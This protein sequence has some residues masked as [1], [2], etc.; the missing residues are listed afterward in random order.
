MP[1]LLGPQGSE[2]IARHLD[3]EYSAGREFFT[4]DL[5]LPNQDFGG[6]EH[7]QY[8][9]AKLARES[10]R[11]G[12]VPIGV[13][14]ELPAN[15]LSAVAA[16]LLQDL[17]D[18]SIAAEVLQEV[19]SLL[20]VY[21]RALLQIAGLSSHDA[22]V[23]RLENLSMATANALMPR[24]GSSR[25][26]ITSDPYARLTIEQNINRMSNHQ[27]S[28]RSQKFL[29]ENAEYRCLISR[30]KCYITTTSAGNQ[31]SIRLGLASRMNASGGARLQLRWDPIKFLNE[32]Y[33]VGHSQKVAD[34]ICIV[35][36]SV[37][38]YA[39]TFLEYLQLVSPTVGTSVLHI[40]DDWTAQ[41]S[42][43]ASCGTS[44]VKSIRICFENPWTN[45][46]L[47]S[48]YIIVTDRSKHSKTTR[49]TSISFSARRAGF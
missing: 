13:D 19:T 11:A 39:S 40:L 46:I 25:R 23:R 5:Q 16:H 38:A 18:R 26:N 45:Q 30:L 3:G 48:R 49:V 22:F 24:H 43:D 2:P 1:K 28:A 42:T 20:Y 47:A 7:G 31:S 37:D 6:A 8:P 17:G 33:G 34:C 4:K 35:G 41:N 10:E 44:S 12:G 29:F 27:L 36:N 32:Q 15:V 21:W 9:H 14:P